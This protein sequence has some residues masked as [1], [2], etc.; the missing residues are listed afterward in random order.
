MK[1]HSSSR[2]AGHPR[3]LGCPHVRCAIGP[4]QVTFD[5]SAPQAA[6]GFSTPTASMDLS[7][8]RQNLS[9]CASCTRGC[10]PA[11]N[12]MTSSGRSSSCETLYLTNIPDPAKTSPTS[13]QGSTSRGPD[14]YEY[15][16]SS[17]RDLY[18]SLLWLPETVSLDSGSSSSSGC[19]QNVE[20][21]SS[22]STMRTELPKTSSERTSWPSY[23]Y[24]VVDGMAAAG[25]SNTNQPQMLKSLKLRLNPNPEQKAKLATMAGCSRFTYNKAVALRLAEGSTQ[26]STFRIRDRIV[27]LQKRGSSSKNTFFHDKA[28]LLECPKSVRQSA[29]ASAVANVKA[30]FSNLK[31]KNIKHFSPPF[32]AKKNETLRG[33]T[34]GMD[35]KNVR[36][37]GDALYVFKDVLGPMRYRGV[38]QLHKLMPNANP[39][40]DPK[41][42]KSAYGEYF[43]VLSI[44]RT[45]RER[46]PL[47]VKLKVS[48][49]GQAVS[50]SLRVHREVGVAAAS[51]DPGV[52]KTMTTYSP[53]NEESFMMGKGHATKLTSLLVT[54]D[55]ML[56]EVTKV[57]TA[58]T[59]Q[60]KKAIKASMVRLR[61]KIFY[62]K[63]EFRDQA[64]NFLA[65][66]YDVLLVPKLG[67]KDM[68]LCAGRKLKTKVVRQMLTLGHS[69][70][71]S[72]LKE[73]CSEYGTVF[74]EVKEHYTSQTCLS[75]GKLN[76]CGEAYA[77]RSCGF[78]CDRDIVG[79]AG[80]FL[81]AVRKMNPSP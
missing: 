1:C 56:S 50:L 58:L 37:D 54:Y 78:H 14:F 52:R 36:K 25:T 77:C 45:P 73:K 61:K 69:Y 59:P 22:F 62:L 72:R 65:C 60:Q 57:N 11:S 46:K 74:L 75:C 51:I 13:D 7:L 49:D 66:R 80:I 2:L 71:F 23:K 6:N 44:D 55:R 3:S 27:T 79:A 17:K 48:A 15:W 19:V 28:W 26:R 18:Q 38:R 8:S 30:C 34:I 9:A 24:I 10:P 5:V 33:W 12:G 68:T 67:T 16:D 29:V 35:Q 63:K 64:T 39:I 40:H 70:I 41:I 53:D 47:G 81:K 4:T 20:L 43:L 76:K 21:S 42:Q 32:K 31:A